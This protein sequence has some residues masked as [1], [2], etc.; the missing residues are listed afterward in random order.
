MKSFSQFTMLNCRFPDCSHTDEDGCAVLEALNN[1][2]IDR[3]SYEN[4]LKLIRE[5]QRF[6]STVAEKRRKD[7]SLSK[8]IKNYYKDMKRNDME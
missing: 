3:E 8:L 4:Y 6:S 7:K 5:Q 1:G 2:T